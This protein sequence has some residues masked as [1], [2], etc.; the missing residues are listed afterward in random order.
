ML[1]GRVV[2]REGFCLHRIFRRVSNSHFAAIEVISNGIIDDLPA[3]IECSRCGLVPRTCGCPVGVVVQRTAGSSVIVALEGITIACRHRSRRHG[4]IKG[5]CCRSSTAVTA[6]LI[7]GHGIGTCV[8]FSIERCIRGD[9]P[10]TNTGSGVVGIRLEVLCTRS[11]LSGVVTSEAVTVTTGDIHGRSSLAKGSRLG[12]VTA[13][14]ALRIQSDGIGIGCP[15]RI[16]SCVGGLIP[17]TCRRAVGFIVLCTAGSSVIVALEGITCAGRLGHRR[18]VGIVC[19]LHRRRS[20][21][22]ALLIERDGIFVC[23]PVSKER[24]A[25][26][27]GIGCTEVI[28]FIA[29]S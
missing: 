28:C 4:R 16:E 12:C 9:V 24:C 21:R 26:V 23:C 19:S 22:T 10:V 27:A 8:P 13:C 1:L 15:A 2:Q 6:L 7:E 3:R 18:H 25:G 20:A 11:V 29:G 5:S 14:T 17:C